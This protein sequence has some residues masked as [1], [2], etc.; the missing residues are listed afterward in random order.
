MQTSNIPNTER[1][2]LTNLKPV[3][4]FL[5]L[6]DIA[7]VITLNKKTLAALAQVPYL[8][9]YAIKHFYLNKAH[10]HPRIRRYFKYLLTKRVKLDFRNVSS[11]EW[12]IF[13]VAVQRTMITRNLIRDA[14]CNKQRDGWVITR[15]GGNG[16]HVENMF[17]PKMY[18]NCLVAS[19]SMCELAYKAKFD[20]FSIKFLKD[21]AAG[22]TL[23]R[24]GCFISRRADCAASGGCRINIY[25]Q[26]KQVIFSK[27]HKRTSEQIPSSW[28]TG[29]EYE[30]LFSEITVN[31][32]PEDLKLEECFVELKIF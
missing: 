10:L 17:V 29:A 9:L 16:W 21:F 4:P 1:L 13:A 26:A 5:T 7:K 20:E 28:D 15:N 27:E 2:L 30:E 25:N 8:V 19:F 14:Y 31:D 22:E 32:L 12:E 3:V 18:T 23:I 24:V 6:F 11:T